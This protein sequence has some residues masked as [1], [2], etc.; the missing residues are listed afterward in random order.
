MEDSGIKVTLFYIPLQF[1]TQM[2]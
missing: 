2:S 1:G